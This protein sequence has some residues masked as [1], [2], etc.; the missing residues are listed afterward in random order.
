[1]FN[2]RITSVQNNQST[3]KVAPI[4]NNI[5]IVY[6]VILDENHLQIKEGNST[7]ADI[8]SIECRML[9][10]IQSSELILARPLVSSITNLPVRNQSVQISKV[11]GDYF[12]EPISKGESPNVTSSDTVISELY[13]QTE[14][15]DSTSKSSD[16]SNSQKTGIAK[17]KNSDLQK[18]DGYGDYFKSEAGI[19]RL[20]LYEGD[21]TLQS[22]FGQSIRFSGYNN[23]ESEFAPTITI[24]NSESALSRDTDFTTTIVEDIN[25]DGSIIL[26][27]S[28]KYIAPF[29][30]GTLSEKGSTD[31]ETQPISFKDFPSELKGDQIIMNSGRLILSSKNAEMIFYSKKNYGF[32][33]DATLSID[34]KLGIEAN[35]GADINIKT[36]D[37]NIN[38]NTGNGK[39]NIGDANLESLVR[40]E[41]LVNLM[42]ELISAIEVMTH[43]TPAGLSAPPLN[44]SSFTKVKSSLKTML[45]NLN[46]TS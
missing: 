17:N 12:Y 38:L 28:G 10:S 3:A 26:L 9:A 27:G 4:A 24:R 6:S 29:Q 21:T 25:R 30:P 7:I 8:G 31:F 13:P 39:V 32:I 18:V 34:N 43:I 5:A 14:Q 40:G 16:Y 42:T 2:Q 19:H 1:M 22:R 37:R 41:T 20:K 15:S 23:S 45:S 11:G 35:V 44:V 46:K 36:N 33:S